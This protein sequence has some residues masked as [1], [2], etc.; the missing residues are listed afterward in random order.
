[1]KNLKLH[2]LLLFLP[3][4]FVS[5]LKAQTEPGGVFLLIAP[6]ARAG[7]MG[8]AQVAL[9]NDAYA[10]YWNPAGLA[11]T[12]GQEIAAMHMNWLPGL[13]DDI[14]YDFLAYRRSLGAHGALGFHGIYLS[15]GEVVHT[16][17]SGPEPLDKFT[18]YM[19]STGVS[20]AR[21][22]SSNL[23]IGLTVKYFQQ[24]LAPARVLEEETVD[25]VSGNIALDIGLFKQQMWSDRVAVGLTLSNLG[26]AITFFDSDRADPA[27]TRFR[28]GV[29]VAVL[30]SDQ[31]TLDLAYDASK[32]LALR[33]ASGGALPISQALLEG[34][35]GNTGESLWDEL[36]H[37]F[38]GELRIFQS[39]ALRAGGVYQESGALHL[40]SGA[41]IPTLGVGL[42]YKGLGG[43]FGY[44]LGNKNHP[45]ANTMR[46]S[47]NIQ[48]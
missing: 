38:G 8:E 19:W 36:L 7:G 14:A 12:D 28:T 25:A 45:L 30:R 43:D 33:D 47:M 34:W 4:F 39:L 1:M 32:I 11:F 18:S 9:A 37:N 6:G 15:L 48:F 42:R 31:V 23:S 27:P 22:L 21:N 24:F 29:K 17:P 40:E 5:H 13:A 35:I 10:A 41:P 26:S 44:I 20:Y 3:L 46:F 16:G 2:I